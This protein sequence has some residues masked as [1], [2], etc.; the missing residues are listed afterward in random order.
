MK[1]CRTEKGLILDRN[2]A[3][4]IRNGEDFKW[5]AVT[6]SHMIY[7]K[8]VA[9]IILLGFRCNEFQFLSID[10][11]RTKVFSLFPHSAQYS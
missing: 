9:R 7:T 4:I 2:T 1:N 5:I 11:K 10:I 8:Y 6:W 3:E